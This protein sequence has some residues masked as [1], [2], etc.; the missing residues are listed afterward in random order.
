[1]E[2]D[3]MVYQLAGTFCVLTC[4]ISMWHMT[5][6]L[7]HLHEPYVQVNLKMDIDLNTLH[8]L[9]LNIYSIPQPC[10]SFQR[11][12]L[13]I[14]WMCPIYSVTSW[15]SLV[16]ISIEGYLAIIKDLYEAYCIYT[17]LS[18]IIAVLGRG[19][20]EAVISLL[21]LHSDHLPEPVQ[22]CGWCSPKQFESSRAKADAVLLQCQVFAMQFVFFRPL[23]SMLTFIFD[24]VGLGNNVPIW[25]SPQNWTSMV[26]NISITFAFWGLLR[27]YHLVQND[28]A[29]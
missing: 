7:R 22:L 10:F 27:I 3:F 26:E 4:L 19:D 16:F 12:I 18:F 8:I 11:K 9:F 17:F 23:T 13:A 25:A 21:E 24:K 28:L 2:N 15:L 5:D 6:H 14:L 20:R 29:W 1:M